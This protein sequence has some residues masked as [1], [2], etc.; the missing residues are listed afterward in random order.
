MTPYRCGL[1]GCIME[2]LR[3]HTVQTLL[4]KYQ[5]NIV[6]YAA[7]FHHSTRTDR[8]TLWEKNDL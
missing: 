5:S 1:V 2:V 8:D 3:L 4:N 7:V 6:T